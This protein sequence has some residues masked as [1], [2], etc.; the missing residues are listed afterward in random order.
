MT[1]P[2]VWIHG[3]YENILHVFENRS[4]LHVYRSNFF[5]NFVKTV[6]LHN[7][8]NSIT[9]FCCNR[10]FI[11]ILCALIEFSIANESVKRIN[12]HF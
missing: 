11:D 9:I 8:C 10:C 2:E 3:V 6:R 5:V 1:H 7:A 4:V 12:R